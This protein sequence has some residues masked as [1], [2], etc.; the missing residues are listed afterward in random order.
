MEKDKCLVITYPHPIKNLFTYQDIHDGCQKKR[1]RETW[2]E[3]VQDILICSR[4]F[5]KICTD[6]QSTKALRDELEEAVL[7]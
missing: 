3:T 4:T 7:T 1:R 2:D 5:G 6:I